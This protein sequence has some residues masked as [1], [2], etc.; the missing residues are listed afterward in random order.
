MILSGLLTHQAPGVIAAYRARDLVPLRHLRIDGWSSLLLRAL[1][2]DPASIAFSD[3]G[4]S[5]PFFTARFTR[6]AST[7]RPSIWT[8]TP[9]CFV[10]IGAIGPRRTGRR[11]FLKCES[12]HCVSPRR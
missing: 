4:R 2:A 7:K 10:S 3:G 1:F 9:R 6:R 11:N 12:R 8:M 5:R